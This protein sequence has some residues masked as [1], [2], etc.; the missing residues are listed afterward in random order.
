MS[1]PPKG[2][3]EKALREFLSEAQ[4]IVEAF[5]RDLLQLDEGRAASRYDPAVLNDAFRAVHSLKGLAGLFG[6]ASMTNLSHNLENLLDSLRMGRLQVTPEILDLLFAAV[7]HFGRLIAETHAGTPS[8]RSDVGDLILQID[9]VAQQRPKVEDTPLGG[10]EIDAGTLS[11]LTEYEEHRLKEN[12]REGRP[13]LRVHAAFELAAIDKSL[14]DLQRRLKPLSEVI[15]YLP[16]PEGGDESRIELDVIIG[17]KSPLPA[18]EAEVVAA[19]ATVHPV[20][21]RTTA[22]A[23]PPAAPR[24]TAP[25]KPPPPPSAAPPSAGPPRAAPA[26]RDAGPG[27]GAGG[28]GPE[29]REGGEPHDLHDGHE[30]PDAERPTSL[31]SVSQ[32][33]RVDIRKLD[34]LMNVVGELQ[35]TRAGINAVLD[36]LKGDPTQGEVARTLHRES[37]ALERKVAELQAGILEVRM[38]PLGQVLDK[39]SRV[40]RK[41]SRESQKEIRF[42]ISGADTELDK[43]IVEE[44]SDP[45]MHIIRNSIDHGIESAAARAAAGKPETGTIALSAYHRGNHVVIDIE[46]DG[47]GFDEEKLVKSAVA[48]GQLTSEQA[49]ELSRREIH[50][51]IFLPGVS[52]KDK[53]D[54]VSGRGVGMDVVKTNIARL[55]GIIDL[56]SEPGHGTK[57]S[58]TLPIT[59]AIIPALVIRAAGRIY[60]IPLNSVLESVLIDPHELKTIERREVYTLRGQTLPLLRLEDAFHLRPAGEATGRPGAAALPAPHQYIVVVGL[61]Q[62]RLG[63]VADELTG[64]QDIVIKS[65][66]RVLSEIPGIAGATE[67]GGQQTVL[68]LDVAALVEETV[69]PTGGGAEAVA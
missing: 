63:L 49:A 53:A 30:G 3:S 27:P 14:E 13:L 17:A 56:W 21:R 1:E 57:I 52:T 11:V 64:Q 48:H 60:A 7:E 55:S 51:L 40:V 25:P 44:L 45:L 9:R 6:L 69:A 4:E 38:V 31:R 15:T 47:V 62:H 26:G 35:L 39:L 58:I 42:V 23:A 19:G 67:L 37:R 10:Y 24:A 61:A 22:P 68:V 43:L 20:P 34:A 28:E 65:L 29:G 59:L 46:D 5:N 33:V 12:I 32:T 41:I 54:E 36:R 2:G 8:E 18:I 50:N 16:S 66:G